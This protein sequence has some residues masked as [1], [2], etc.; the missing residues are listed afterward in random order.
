MRFVLFA[1]LFVVAGASRAAPYQCPPPLG[2]SQVGCTFV[3]PGGT[4][5]FTA[6][7][8]A[9][10]TGTAGS[11]SALQLNMSLDAL[12][13]NSNSGV[14]VPVSG[15]SSTLTVNGTC[16][17]DV[18]SRRPVDLLVVAPNYNATA[19][20]I[21]LIAN[22]VAFV[23]D[24]Q[25]AVATVGSGTVSSVDGGIDCGA[26]CV[27]SYSPGA[28]VTLT[29]NAAAGWV[30]SAWGGD[31]TGTVLSCTL[32]MSQIRNVTAHFEFE[33]VAAV[34]EFRHAASDRYF[35]TA[36]PAEATAI[37]NGNAGPGW[38][39]TGLSFKAGGNTPVCRFYGS[40]S[41]GPNSHFY[42]A[43]AE[44]CNFL[45][46]LAATTP[47]SQ[48]RWNFEGIAFASSLP[49]GG[50]CL[51]GTLPVYRA[52]N[53]G[54]LTGKDSNHRITTNADAIQQVVAQ[55]W[56]YEGVAMCAPQ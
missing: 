14:W 56:R 16:T 55:G 35:I 38:A 34:V 46:Q 53:N 18:T 29:A 5:T 25:L 6:N 17:F 7:A 45:K 1:V 43:V 28:T 24:F 44:E 11:G 9:Q 4:T 39:R 20:Y 27:E 36:N 33:F 50:M 48:P 42:S 22:S 2:P 30:F 13:C 32:G 3:S 12:P 8:A 15:S 10:I 51:P 49:V 37:D 23:P 54:Y 21:N 52:Y 47:A 41:P 26:D 31:C 40:P 19:M